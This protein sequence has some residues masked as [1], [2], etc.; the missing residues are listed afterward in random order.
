MKCT[1]LALVLFCLNA[2]AHA[3]SY[4]FVGTW[5]GTG[6]WTNGSRDSEVPTT[7][8]LTIS[9]GDKIFR[10]EECWDYKDQNDGS[11]KHSCIE[12]SYDRDSNDS[13]SV[14]GKKV[15]DIFADHILIFVGTS[16]VSEQISIDL[17]QPGKLLYRYNY[18]NSD[19]AAISREA[20]L[21]Q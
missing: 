6:T 12:S 18:L 21:T 15:G 4:G 14:Q 10:F 11:P 2:I 16:E 13:L 17:L 5:K 3:D 19:G 20:K 1:S 7:T 9:E 8:Q